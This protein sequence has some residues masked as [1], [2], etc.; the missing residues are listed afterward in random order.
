MQSKNYFVLY[1]E[2]NNNKYLRCDLNHLFISHLLIDNTKMTKPIIAVGSIAL[3]SLQTVQ[4]SKT[5]ILGGSCTYFGLAANLFSP[6]S[7]VG[8]VGND[9]PQE[10]WDLF[11]NKK[12]DTTNHRLVI[13]I[14][15]FFWKCLPA[16]FD[17]PR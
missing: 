16:C 10:H 14:V 11:S 5:E 8:V 15:V 9:F 4:G 1:Q 2:E 7:L 13:G 17:I 3:D 12:I 6:T